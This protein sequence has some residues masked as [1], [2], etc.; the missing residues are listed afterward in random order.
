MIEDNEREIYIW[1]VLN[2][3]P[4]TEKEMAEENHLFLKEL[5]FD[6][7]F[8]FLK[9]KNEEAVAKLQEGWKAIEQKYET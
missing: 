2:Y 3:H 8:N 7:I 1:N 4:P 9:S 5:Y 6:L